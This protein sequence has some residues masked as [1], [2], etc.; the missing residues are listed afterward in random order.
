MSSGS[1]MS[2]II[3]AAKAGEACHIPRN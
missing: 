1:F 2:G 3:G